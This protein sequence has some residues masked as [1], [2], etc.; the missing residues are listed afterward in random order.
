LIGFHKFDKRIYDFLNLV[1]YFFVSSF[2]MGSDVF[3]EI[4]KALLPVFPSCSEVIFIK[5]VNF[6]Q[7]PPKFNVKSPQRPGSVCL[8]F[9]DSGVADSIE[10]HDFFV[11]TGEKETSHVFVLNRFLLCFH[12]EYHPPFEQFVMEYLE[13]SS[14]VVTSFTNIF[15]ILLH[16]Q[17]FLPLSIFI[18]LLIFFKLT[19]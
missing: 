1:I 10:K 15:I 2:D 16:L 13:I 12:F 4:S 6:I 14:Y 8:V 19:F 11:P 9:I 7:S 3:E 17:Q 18:R 5:F